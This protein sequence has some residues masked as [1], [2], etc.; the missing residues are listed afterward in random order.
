M[1]VQKPYYRTWT[2]QP[3]RWAIPHCVL[4]S[5][6]ILP[7]ACDEITSPHSMYTHCESVGWPCRSSIR[8]NAPGWPTLNIYCPFLTCRLFVFPISHNANTVTAA[9]LTFNCGATWQHTHTHTS[10]PPASPEAPRTDTRHVSSHS[11]AARAPPS[12]RTSQYLDSE[13]SLRGSVSLLR[14]LFFFPPLSLPVNISHH[15]AAVAAA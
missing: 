2:Y 3:E 6:I 8:I 9:A 15:S 10:A 13:R 1:Y 12:S 14:R 11:S 7:A 5:Y 4:E